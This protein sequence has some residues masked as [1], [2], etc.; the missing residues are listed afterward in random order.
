MKRTFDQVAWQVLPPDAPQ[1]RDARQHE[2]H[3]QRLEAGSKAAAAECRPVS[4]K[5]MHLASVQEVQLTY[6]LTCR[7]ATEDINS[8]QLAHT[9][10]RHVWD[11]TNRATST[12]PSQLGPQ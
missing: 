7:H 12:A 5:T 3:A 1:A 9:L 8:C 2:R 6:H 11:S 4:I 10:M